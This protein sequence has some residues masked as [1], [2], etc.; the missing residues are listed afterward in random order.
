MTHDHRE[1]SSPNANTSQ[2]TSEQQFSEMH[3][4][5][6]NPTP[7]PQSS[8]TQSDP[9]MTHP[10]SNDPNFQAEG[11]DPLGQSDLS[12]QDILEENQIL[13]ERNLRLMAEMENLRRRTEREISDKQKYAVSNFA[14]DV[15]GVGDNLQRAIDAAPQDATEQDSDIKPFI[16]G[17]VMTERELLN[18]LERYGVHKVDPKGD[19]FDPNLHQAMF[20]AENPALP[21]GTI[22]EVIQSGYTIGDRVL[23][24]ALVG[25]AKGGPK[26]SPAQ[27]GQQDLDHQEAAQQEGAQQEYTSERLGA[28]DLSDADE[29]QNAS[30][31]SDAA[32]GNRSHTQTEHQSGPKARSHPGASQHHE[33]TPNTNG[34]RA[35]GQGKHIDRNA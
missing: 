12:L 34:E 3:P 6:E 24:P 33:Q 19:L 7:G 26:V 4:K 25:I 23:R 9:K 21:S 1:P 15:L 18:V 2:E 29:D 16:E 17:V 20:E 22:M 30:H 28:H 35:Q 14:R 13:K 32:A 31:Q 8:Q 10:R 5:E 27:A 11:Q